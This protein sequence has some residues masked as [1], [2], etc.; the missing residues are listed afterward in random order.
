MAGEY[1]DQRT[2]EQV[3]N[4]PGDGSSV[5]RRGAQEVGAVLQA[6]VQAR[7]VGL[8]LRPDAAKATAGA[9]EQGT[10]SGVAPRMREEAGQGRSGDSA[11]VSGDRGRDTGGSSP[12]NGAEADGEADSGSAE[13]RRENMASRKRTSSARRRPD[14]ASPSQGAAEPVAS[15]SA[16]AVLRPTDGRQR[17][18]AQGSTEGG[19]AAL[20]PDAAGAGVPGEEGKAQGGA[21]AA[22]DAMERDTASLDKGGRDA[23]GMEVELPAGQARTGGGGLQLDPGGRSQ[24]PGMAALETADEGKDDGEET[25]DD[26]EL[27]EGPMMDGAVD[28]GWESFLPRGNLRVLLVEDDDSTR[29]VVGALLRNCG[30][31]GE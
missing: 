20:R 27:H 19:D 12:S 23:E 7:Q 25:G 10:E 16:E 17:E 2:D 4:R 24:K 11:R 28:G 8:R 21:A 3:A 29:H 31:E 6:E 18:K 15:K 5:G 26:F 30:Y 14:A 22:Q 9:A 1:G 13:R